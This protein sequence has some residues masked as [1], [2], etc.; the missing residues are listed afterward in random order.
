MPGCELTTFGTRVSSH[1][2][3]LFRLPLTWTSF[4]LFVIETKRERG[5]ECHGHHGRRRH[6]LYVLHF[7]KIIR[8]MGGF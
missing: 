6:Q 5:Q 4:T 1:N 8:L 7:Y 2:H 3:C